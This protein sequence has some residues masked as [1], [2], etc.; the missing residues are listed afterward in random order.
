MTIRSL[1]P[2]DLP[3]WM[4]PRARSVD[5]GLLIVLVLSLLLGWPLLSR[6]GVPPGSEAE[7]NMFR[8]LEAARI[9][10]SG[11]LYSRWAPDFNHGLGSP[12]FNY[13]APLAHYLPGY[14]QAF[15]D[16]NPMDSINL[17]LASSIVAAGTGMFLY[18]RQRWGLVAG[19]V[20]A[21]LYLFSPPV[22][23]TLP[24]FAGDLPLLMAL[25]VLPW[26]LWAI[27]YFWLRPKGRTLAIATA[28][29]GAFL[30]CDARMVLMGSAAILVSMVTLGRFY[31]DRSYEPVMVAVVA[32]LALTAFFWM[33]GV[34]ERDTIRW[35]AGR[36]DARAGQITPGEL[37]ADIP[38]FSPNA[39]NMNISAYRGLGVA[40][41]SLGLLGA[42]AIV[43]QALRRVYL[44]DAIL[45]LIAAVMLIGLSTPAFYS[46]WPPPT[47]FQP[48]LPY[49]AILVAIFCLAVVGA[50]SVR[51][52]EA[53]QPRWQTIGLSVLCLVAPLASLAALYPPEPASQPREPTVATLLQSELRGEHTGT[54]RSGVLLPASAP[55]LP[56]P[57]P[58]LIETVQDDTFDRIN[59]R[60]YS[61]E[62]QVNPVD[63]GLFYNRYFFNAARPLDVEFNI[64]YYPGWRVS[65]DGKQQEAQ[66]SA[67]GLLTVTVPRLSGELAVWLEGTPLRYLSWAMTA[68][69][70]GFLF[71]AMRRLRTLGKQPEAVR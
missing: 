29:L 38:R 21:L 5:W 8:S 32:A 3:A 70:A 49:H 56:D 64:L 11:T 57:L 55:E 47:S 2:E 71:L 67:Q 44:P 48:V 7:L 51:W 37:L 14:H 43:W 34:V 53:L 4:R 16:T 26:T 33:P 54:F 46:L 39:Q 36:V 66:P 15:T 28:L 18:A 30:L 31:R 61:A 68:G 27:D 9:I 6:R 59:R 52:L 35:E 24:Y 58:N 60:L 63:H 13:L 23:L 50:Q 17:F 65:V 1:R 62:V 20:G 19:L 42:G 22:S 12:L 40:L 45:F 25:G 69:G 41:W 10:R